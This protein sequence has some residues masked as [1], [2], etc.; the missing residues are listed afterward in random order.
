MLYVPLI[1]LFGVACEREE[2]LSE[3]EKKWLK[4]RQEN[5]LD[6]QATF[7]RL[8][9]E[10]KLIAAGCGN[11]LSP[12]PKAVDKDVKLVFATD[13]TLSVF[14]EGSLSRSTK[15]RIT[16]NPSYSGTYAVETSPSRDNNLYTW[17]A[18]EFCEDKVVFN[19]G[20]IDGALYYFQKSIP[21]RK[22]KA[23]RS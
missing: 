7:T 18:V 5:Q 1:L 12:G 23:T 13:S 22:N 19:N 20:Y 14:E 4:C 16:P 3:A 9:G 21:E 11:C 6:E 10:W 15:F 17:G 2:T 8:M